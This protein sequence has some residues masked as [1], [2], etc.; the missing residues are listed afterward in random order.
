[1]EADFAD[2]GGSI[3][4]GGGWGGGDSGSGF[5]GGWGGGDGGTVADSS[6]GGMG[7]ITEAQAQA[8][9]QAFAASLA[10]YEASLTPIEPVQLVPQPVANLRV[11][12][13][14]SVDLGQMVSNV[15]TAILGA[16]GIASGTPAGVVGGVRSV[17]G[18]INAPSAFSDRL[19]ETVTI[20]SP[21]PSIFS[22]NDAGMNAAP[23]GAAF[24]ADTGG[25]AGDG[26]MAGSPVTGIGGVIIGA[27]QTTTNTG[28]LAQALAALFEPPGNTRQRYGTIDQKQAAPGIAPGV[29]LAGL[30][31]LIFLG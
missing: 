17:Q 25:M 11:D 4:G 14:T 8:Q 18:V 1:M 6:I 12:R 3:G 26:G 10:P 22:G 28:G 7:P 27:P 20:G 30:A 23:A 19:V 2:S 15:T 9:A 31:G 16:L 13:V 5:A 29:A 24:E 21:A